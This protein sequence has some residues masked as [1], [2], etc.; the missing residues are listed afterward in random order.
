[1]LTAPT[2]PSIVQQTGTHSLEI[3]IFEGRNRQIRKMLEVLGYTVETLHRMEFMKIGL[4]PLKRA[5]DWV[6]LDEEEMKMIDG[7]IVG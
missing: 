6:E 4:S 2:L 7:L 5:G 3:T 1:M